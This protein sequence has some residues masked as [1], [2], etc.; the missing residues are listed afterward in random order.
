MLL[1]AVA[2]GGALGALARLGLAGWVQGWAGPSFP[3]G[4]LAVNAAGSLLLGLAL[5]LLE[6]IAAPPE[7]RAFVTVGFLGAFTTFSTF[8]YEA[9]ALCLSGEWVRAAAYAFGSLFAG[10][11]GV[12]AGFALAM[13]IV[14]QGG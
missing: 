13:V 10:A 1:V 7:A 11:V 14:R 2:V 5:R 3:W 6:G 8:S 9:V 12:V 4:T